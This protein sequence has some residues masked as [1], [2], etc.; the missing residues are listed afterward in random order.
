MR[1][2]RA[3]MLGFGAVALGVAAVPVAFF[4]FTARG[5]ETPPSDMRGPVARAFLA[6]EVEGEGSA[7]PVPAV[8]RLFP[9]GMPQ[10]EALRDLDGD[11]FACSR[12]D[13]E[14]LCKRS[15]PHAALAESWTVALRF[16][17]AGVLVARSGEIQVSR[18]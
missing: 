8:D 7:Q 9:L 18:R 6:V 2:G 17:G 3:E 15:I 12:T 10:A 11:G 14:A 5:A 16:D 4:L 13:G 1:E